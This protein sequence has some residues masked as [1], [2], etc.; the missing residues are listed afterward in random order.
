[1]T[2]TGVAHAPEMGAGQLQGGNLI[3]YDVTNFV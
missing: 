2:N 3:S 1:M